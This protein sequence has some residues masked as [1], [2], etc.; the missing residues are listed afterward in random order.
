MAQFQYRATDGDGKVLEGMI[1][2]SDRGAA[3]TRLQDRGLMPLRVAEPGPERRGI[4]PPYATPS[5]C[6]ED[7]AGAHRHH[8]ECE[9]RAG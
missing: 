7:G 9:K 8:Q 4:G 3:A 6:A 1:D 5:R 2:A